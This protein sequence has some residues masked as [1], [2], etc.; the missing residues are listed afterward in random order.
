MIDFVFVVGATRKD[1][2]SPAG[3]LWEHLRIHNIKY[4]IIASYTSILSL[5]A[6]YY[7]SICCNQRVYLLY[8]VGTMTT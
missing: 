6:Q 1:T 2:L 5:E 3:G 4:E 8:D 7:F